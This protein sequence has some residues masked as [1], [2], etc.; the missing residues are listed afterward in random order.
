MRKA[1]DVVVDTRSYKVTTDLSQKPEKLTITVN[2]IIVAV[3]SDAAIEGKHEIYL[4][5]TPA[6]IVVVSKKDE[7]SVELVYQGKY[8]ST[9]KIFS[10]A[11]LIPYK[12]TDQNTADTAERLISRSSNLLLIIFLLQTAYL[13]GAQRYHYTPLP[14]IRDVTRYYL[15]EPLILAVL[16]Y[17]INITRSQILA[18]ILRIYSYAL[19]ILV[20]VTFNEE[21]W[22]TILLAFLI[23]LAVDQLHRGV[24][25]YHAAQ[26]YLDT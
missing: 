3:K 20:L 5:K 8:V 23:I 11:D 24:S 10:D 26:H 13:L 18:W 12:S 22:I 25:K 1:W 16:V 2:D 17:F 6:F 19:L 14:L 9:G 21:R 15:S 4:G 7:C